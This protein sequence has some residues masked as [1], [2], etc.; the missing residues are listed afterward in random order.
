MASK[1]RPHSE[2]KKKPKA[3]DK[4]Q[5]E[6]LLESPPHRWKS[7]SPSASRA[8]S[9]RVRTRRRPLADPR[10]EPGGIPG[11]TITGIGQAGAEGNGV[12]RRGIAID[13]RNAS[14]RAPSTRPSC[15]SRSSSAAARS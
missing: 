6:S 15:R 2:A 8:G 5:L 3:E 4:P 7:S 1:D 11:M 13:R 9:R 14:A 10:T 12:E